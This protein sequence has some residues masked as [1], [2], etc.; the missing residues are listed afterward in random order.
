MKII[1]TFQKHPCTNHTDGDYG[2]VE[3]DCEECNLCRCDEPG[4][5]CGNELYSAYCPDCGCEVERPSC[6]ACNDESCGNCNKVIFVKRGDDVFYSGTVI[7]EWTNGALKTYEATSGHPHLNATHCLGNAAPL[8][9]DVTSKEMALE[10]V[11]THISNIDFNDAV[12]G[13]YDGIGE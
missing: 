9:N 4:Y 2:V 1:I 5:C 8:F 12:G 13:T 10:A 7:A 11:I 6:N 3:D